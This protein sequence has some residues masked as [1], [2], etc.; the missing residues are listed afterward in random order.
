M[1]HACEE[2]NA[3]TEA[4]EVLKAIA[5][6]VRLRIVAI[7]CDEKLHVNALAERLGVTQS[8]VS[9]QLRI[10]RMRQLVGVT[11]EQGKAIYRLTEPNLRKMIKCMDSCLLDRGLTKS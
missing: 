6:P 5:H 8:I 3:A 1:S 7:L 4:A 11:R 9:Q 10:L 2:P